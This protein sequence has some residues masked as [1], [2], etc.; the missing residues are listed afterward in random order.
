M[1]F[2]ILFLLFSLPSFS[3]EIPFCD[4][5]LGR[6][7]FENDHHEMLRELSEG[8]KKEFKRRHSTPRGSIL[9]INIETNFTVPVIGR[10]EYFGRIYLK[11]GDPKIRFRDELLA[12]RN[13]DEEKRDPDHPF[14]TP[15]LVSEINEPDGLSLVKSTG[16]EVNIKSNGSFN[17]NTGGRIFLKVKAPGESSANYVIDVEIK[18]G[19]IQNYIIHNGKKIPFDSLKINADKNFLGITTILSGIKNITFS[20]NGK[21]TLTVSQ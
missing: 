13:Y 1:P 8:I 7:V 11:P 6:P 14:Y 2:F 4:D 18:E 12:E 17:T 3:N 20:Q 9:A 19:K 5:Y 21:I 15:Y 10:D 16:A